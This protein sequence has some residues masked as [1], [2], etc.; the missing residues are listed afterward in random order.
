MKEILSS[1]NLYSLLANNTKI[2]WWI[3]RKT[4]QDLADYDKKIQHLFD[5]QFVEKADMEYELHHTYLPAIQYTEETR[6]EQRSTQ[7]LI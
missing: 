4:L 3:L 7:F 6:T 1:G 2:S 5:S